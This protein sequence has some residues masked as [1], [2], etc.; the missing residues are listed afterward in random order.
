[1]IHND[2]TE[3]APLRYLTVLPKL[4]I[5]KTKL[6]ILP[7]KAFLLLSITMS[8]MSSHPGALGKDQGVGLDISFNLNTS[9]YFY[10]QYMCLNPS[11]LAPTSSSHH[12]LL[13]CFPTIILESSNP[14]STPPNMTIL[15]PNL[16]FPPLLGYNHS[17][18][19][20]VDEIIIEKILPPQPVSFRLHSCVPLT[21]GMTMW[22]TL[23]N[24][25][26]VDVAQ[27][28]LCLLFAGRRALCASAITMKRASSGSYWPLGLCPRM[29][30]V[31]QTLLSWP[32][33][34]QPQAKPTQ[35]TCVSKK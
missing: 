33:D 25:M 27:Q 30:H 18:S 32:S 26:L 31:E 4:N 8:S 10:L 6:I 12:H 21:L 13:S 28:K 20:V 16:L 35:L 24:G 22:L 23:S 29:I 34:L 1:M 7:H 9:C 19:S 15:K 5:W 11:S 17:V 14:F 2:D 3:D